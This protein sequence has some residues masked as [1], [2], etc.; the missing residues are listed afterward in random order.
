[1]AAKALPD[2]VDRILITEEQLQ[3][4]VTEMAA[5][6]VRSFGELE[7]H[8]T[9]VP[10]LH[11]SLIFLADLMRRM[12]VKMELGLLTVS[13]YPG[14]AT[15]STGAPEILMDVAIDLKGR[16]VLLIDDILDTGR[17]LRKVTQ[18]L[19]RKGLRRLKIAT[20]LRKPT[21]APPELIVDFVGFDI[22]DAFVVGYGLDYNNYYRNLPYIAVLKEGAVGGA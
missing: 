6:I 20:L 18:R 21:K 12:P 5:E 11:G 4:R 19:Q 16:D 8:L 3:G 22:E 15:A 1:M 14:T 9:L 10:I 17:T 2:F 13:S 7:S